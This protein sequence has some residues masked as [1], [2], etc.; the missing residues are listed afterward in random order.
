MRASTP[1]LK[2]TEVAAAV[3]TRCDG[4]FLL[5]QRP[6]G[7]VYSG[8]WEFP[9]GKVERNETPRSALLRELEEELG[10]TAVRFYPWITREFPYPHAYVRLHFFRVVEWR[11]QIQDH[12]HSALS[13][14]TA[15]NPSVGPMLPANAPIL[16]ALALPD[17]Y[18][19][20]HAWEIGADA[21]LAQLEA[22]LE[23]GLRLVQLREMQLDRSI[24]WAGNVISLAHRYGARVLVNGD[25]DLARTLDADGLHLKSAQLMHLDQRPDLPM[26]AASC[27]DAEQLARAQQ[28][29]L[30]FVVLGPVM[31][32]PSHG[33][34]PGIG[35]QHF[36]HLNSGCALPVY[37]I[38]GLTGDDRPAAWQRGAH[39]VAAIRGAWS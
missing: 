38:G 36:E 22:A 20:T 11:G 13:W 34:A 9:G 16:R 26:V 21:Q 28:L 29:D 12:I 37:A 17:L 8:Y 24:E 14:Q 30:D 18:G 10:I 23:R 35:W 1:P 33:D 32:T 6:T 5:G 3:I 31:S 2:V 4:S 19:I 39:G 27:H 25:A 15:D 7:A